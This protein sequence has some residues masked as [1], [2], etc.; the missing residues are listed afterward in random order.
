VIGPP[1]I[2][3]ADG[4]PAMGTCPIIAADG[5]PCGDACDTFAECFDPT[6]PAGTPRVK[7]TCALLDSVVCR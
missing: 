2:P 6:S 4:G 7:G 3:P 1:L 5:Q